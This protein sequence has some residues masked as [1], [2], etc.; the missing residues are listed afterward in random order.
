MH[1]DA[2]R[3]DCS[4]CEQAILRAE[5]LE[6]ALND[7]SV[8]DH[9]AECGECREFFESLREVR[10]ALDQYRVREPSEELIETVLLRAVQPH[11]ADLVPERARVDAGVF[12]VLLAGLVS[13]P[14][15]ILINAMMGWALYEVAISLLPRTIALYCVGLFVVWA[16]L[17]MSFGYASLPF[18]GA[19]VNRPT[20]R[21]RIANP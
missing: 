14:L 17:A 18:L 19:F 6:D 21:L 13:L 10:P 9:V 3:L 20:G 4:A 1:R 16:S 12:R 5:A 15:V 11:A 7:S 8:A 2:G